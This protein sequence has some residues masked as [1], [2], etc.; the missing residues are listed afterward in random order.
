M[1]TRYM[2][3][4]KH[5]VLS[6]Q[7]NTR[8][9]ENAVYNAD[10][11]IQKHCYCMINKMTRSNEQLNRRFI[12]SRVY[13]IYIYKFCIFPYPSIPVDGNRAS[14]PEC[15]SI[16]LYSFSSQLEKPKMMLNLN[17][18]YLFCQMWTL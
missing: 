7:P 4:N 2:C 16:T 9:L 13:L 1:R 11:H 8:E 15:T 18:V 17:R 10:P 14:H 6:C 3:T 12:T 5:I